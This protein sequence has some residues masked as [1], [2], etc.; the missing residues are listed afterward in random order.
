MGPSS[1]L[2]AR[3]SG[4]PT[5]DGICPV[6]AAFL[7]AVVLK[8]LAFAVGRVGM[9]YLLSADLGGTKILVALANRE[10]KIVRLQKFP[11]EARAGSD[12]VWRNLLGALEEVLSREGAPWHK[13]AGLGVCAAGFFDF[14]SRTIIS[15]PNLPGWEGFPL[16]ER[17]RVELDL[18]VLIE[19]DAN[20][21]AFGEF[22]FGAGRGKR[23]MIN[24]TLGTGIGGG[25]I[26]EGEIYRGSGGFAGE[27]GHIPVLPGGPPCGCGRYGCLE[28][29]SSG[30]AI[31]RAGRAAVAGGKQTIL[32]KTV[33]D[34]REITA[35]HVFEAAEAGD[36]EAVKIVERANY[37]LGRALAAVVNILNPD[38]ITLGG[39]MARAGEIIFASVRHHL[40][41][42]AIKPSG[43]MV[44]VVPAILGEEAGV[45]GML[46]LLE[47]FLFQK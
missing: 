37:Y 21:A 42:A 20:A 33:R 44:E 5:R 22:T 16:E 28:S 25:I 6:P 29:L 12:N 3:F 46:A 35:R 24:I 41:A 26:I 10:G 47:Q 38:L 11:T 15:S 23:N 27:I 9:E 19:N 39:G 17:L 8:K 36:V 1:G 32:Q 43:E 13:L 18:P 2:R 40:K 30:T 45:K 31:A 34:G 4:A 7:G 14:Y